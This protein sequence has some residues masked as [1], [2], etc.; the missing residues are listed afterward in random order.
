MSSTRYPYEHD[1][2]PGQ[3]PTKCYIQEIDSGRGHSYVL[4]EHPENK[5]KHVS[6]VA[7]EIGD[8]LVRKEMAENPKFEPER[9]QLYTE[10]P[11]SERGFNDEPRFAKLEAKTTQ[12]QNVSQEPNR[13]EYKPSEWR[14]SDGYRMDKPE[15][16]RNV[17]AEIETNP[18]FQ[19]QSIEQQNKQFA[20][21][22]M[23]RTEEA[24]QMRDAA[25]Q[26]QARQR[27]R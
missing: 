1:N 9:L 16:E 4:S 19:D 3:E 12:E 17:G 2:G 25:Q 15:A 14:W 23:P 24:Q 7:P 22:D 18:R 6:Q 10:R 13:F 5:G 21:A 8:S 20:E 11:A 26:E 27:Q